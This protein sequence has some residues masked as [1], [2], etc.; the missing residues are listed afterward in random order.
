[1]VQ[2]VLNQ[3][4]VQSHLPAVAAVVVDVGFKVLT[5]AQAAVAEVQD[6]VAVHQLQVQEILHQFHLHK[7]VQ[8]VQLVEAP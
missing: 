1:M 5:E 8:A 7:E 2:Q 4:S 3:Y 6:L